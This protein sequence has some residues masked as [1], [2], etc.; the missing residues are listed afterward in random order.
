MIIT[1]LAGGLGNQL[2]QYALGRR[3]S[4][5]HQ[6]VLKI[7]QLDLVHTLPQRSY[8]LSHFNIEEHFASSD[9][10]A[11]RRPRKWKRVWEGLKPYYWRHHII[12]KNMNFDKNL[13]KSG[14]DIYL[15]GFWQ[16]PQ[17]FQDI[18]STLQKDLT[19]KNLPSTTNQQLT[20]LMHS[21]NSVAI[22]VRRMDFAN[23]QTISQ[24]HGTCS[25]E[26]YG[27]VI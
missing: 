25:P 5:H 4:L 22:H 11:A 1:R 7:D 6:T 20:D 21:Q 23:D 27:H 10:I 16:S 18:E 24:V 26:Y 14:P 13:F 17:Y 2:F 12:E 15:Q 19:F 9:E 3:L 8:E